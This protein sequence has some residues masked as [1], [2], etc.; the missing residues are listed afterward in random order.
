MTFEEVKEILYN[1]YDIEEDYD[2]N[3][4]CGCYVGDNWLSIENV[5][6]LLKKEWY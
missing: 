3:A 4:Q 6:D 1:A 5:L 2:Y